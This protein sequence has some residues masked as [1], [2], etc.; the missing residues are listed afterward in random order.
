MSRLERAGS[1]R[2]LTVLEGVRG[3]VTFELIRL[4]YFSEEHARYLR[5]R[6]L[7]QGRDEEALRSSTPR[8]PSGGRGTLLAIHRPMVIVRS[9]AAARRGGRQVAAGPDDG[10]AAIAGGRS[11]PTPLVEL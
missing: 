8:K 2:A 3:E 5:G 9:P 6:L 10:G 1:E 11:S 7:S 4:P